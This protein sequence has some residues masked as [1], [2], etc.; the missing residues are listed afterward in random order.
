MTG[1][2]VPHPVVMNWSYPGAEKVTGDLRE[3]ASDHAFY[4]PSDLQVCAPFKSRVAAINRGPAPSS[5]HDDLPETHNRNYVIIEN[6]EGI[7]WIRHIA[8]SCRVDDE[9]EEGQVLGESFGYVG[10]PHVHISFR[11]PDGGLWQV[12][13]ADIPAKSNP[14]YVAGQRVLERFFP[15][16]DVQRALMMLQLD[17]ELRDKVREAYQGVVQEM[18][19]SL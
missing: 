18:S 1:I 3:P 19:L 7:A 15:Q 5:I 10:T 13:F 11:R 8:S 16:I 4:L 14:E 2:M 17:P 6:G 12:Q 9:V